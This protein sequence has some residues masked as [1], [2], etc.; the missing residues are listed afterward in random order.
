MLYVVNAAV[1]RSCYGNRIS[2]LQLN[3]HSWACC[4]RL[5][6]NH[7]NALYTSKT[8]RQLSGGSSYSRQ[9]REG[10]GPYGYGILNAASVDG[11]SVLRINP[12]F[13][14]PWDF[15]LRF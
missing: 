13:F 10:R 7:M 5:V 15:L 3:A 11:H 8:H 2:L 6:N 4:F 1:L 14:A 9:W 12:R